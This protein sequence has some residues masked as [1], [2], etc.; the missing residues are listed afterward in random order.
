MD[1]NG[2]NMEKERGEICRYLRYITVIPWVK[3]SINTEVVL[4]AFL[5]SAA[6]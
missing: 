5:A 4:G 3:F 1:G 2:W 6:R